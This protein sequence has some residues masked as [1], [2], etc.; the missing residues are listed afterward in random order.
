MPRLTYQGNL[1]EAMCA[2]VEL[3]VLY[4]TVLLDYKLERP[5]LSLGAGPVMLIWEPNSKHG[6]NA[7]C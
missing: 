2:H 4:C 5:K 6:G 3:T 7:A 1:P